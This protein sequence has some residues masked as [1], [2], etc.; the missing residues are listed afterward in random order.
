MRRFERRNNSFQTSQRFRCRNRRVVANRRIFRAPLLCQ[1]G[2]FGPNTRIV[3][4]GGN[5]VRQRHLTIRAL[6]NI[7]IGS[8]QHAWSRAVITAC[9]G[10]PSGMFAQNFA[11]AARFHT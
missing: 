4:S 9:G 5:R 2:M 11:A 3:E 7:G 10:E 8:L 1:P 6:Q